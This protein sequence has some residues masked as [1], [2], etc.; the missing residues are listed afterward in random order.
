ML[1]ATS[2]ASTD[3]LVQAYHDIQRVTDRYKNNLTKN[4]AKTQ[5]L[6]DVANIK[7]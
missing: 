2:Q 1:S 7:I 4:K 6:L 3:P 5:E